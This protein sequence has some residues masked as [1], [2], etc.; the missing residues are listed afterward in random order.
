M[1]RLEDNFS[2]YLSD[3]RENEDKRIE[4]ELIRIENERLRN[5]YWEQI[6]RDKKSYYKRFKKV[7]KTVSENENTFALPEEY[8][9]L[10]MLDVYVNG[11]YLNPSEYDVVEKNV[12]LT[13]WL[14]LVGTVVELV[15]TRAIGITEA[16]YDDLRGLQGFSA[17]EVAVENGFRG[18][19]EEWLWSLRGSGGY[20]RMVSY[21]KTRMENEK[22]IA[23]PYVYEERHLLDVFV[24][25]FKLSE[26]EYWVEEVNGAYFLVLARALDVVGTVVELDVIDAFPTSFEEVDPTVPEWAKEPVKPS[27]TAEEVGA[28]RADTELFSGDY[29]DLR[30][31]PEIPSIEG[32]ASEEFVNGKLDEINEAMKN[33]VNKE[34]GKGLSSNDFIDELKNKLVNLENYDDGEIRNLIAE[35]EENCKKV[36][37]DE[38]EALRRQIPSGEATG[39]SI[40]LMDSS[41]LR[42]EKFRIGGN[43]KQEGEGEPSVD[44]PVEI[45]ACGVNGRIRVLK[46]NE[47]LSE[48]EEFEMP[49]Q[50]E[51]LK[52]DYLEEDGEHHVMKRVVFDGT[53]DWRIENR[54][55]PNYEGNPQTFVSQKILD[56]KLTNF[57]YAQKNVWCNWSLCGRYT[58]RNVGRGLHEAVEC[59]GSQVWVCYERFKDFTLDEFKAYLAEQYANGT[60]L[61]VVYELAEPEVL[62][63]TEEQKSVYGQIQKLKSC[64]NETIIYSSDEV[65]PQF[66]VIYKRDLETMFNNFE[67]R[68]NLLESE[69]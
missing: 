41:D 47:D 26:E 55:D 46:T 25:G 30:N 60:P 64:K 32:L 36:D 50:R 56:M 23:L 8:T 28:L 2:E 15:V 44:V 29:G 39:E 40:T 24:N 63:Y 68:L 20:E 1:I 54:S 19:M 59:G 69:G 31:K 62:P 45:K 35:L 21:Y 53:E 67:T 61:E 14:D 52:G 57:N 17:Y 5:E 49:V 18:T 58:A 6:L 12:V 51:M 38:I 3:I 7:Y 13:K 11:F 48:T 16:D 27:Y 10:G 42:F 37:N 4:N 22:R 34:T 9:P 33:K 65:G 43:T 66:D